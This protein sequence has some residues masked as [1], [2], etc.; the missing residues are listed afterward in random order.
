MIKTNLLESIKIYNKA[1]EVEK[2]GNLNE[3]EKLYLDVI[4][5]NPVLFHCLIWCS[6]VQNTHRP[7]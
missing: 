1:V 4:K 7:R 6:C 2:S 3:A 5:T